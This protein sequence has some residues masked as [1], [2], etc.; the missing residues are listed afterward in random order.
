[1]ISYY[2][3]TRGSNGDSL[4]VTML[5]HI[6]SWGHTYLYIPL[7]GTLLSVVSCSGSSLSVQT[8]IQCW[9][10]S[11]TLFCVLGL[12]FAALLLV[13]E[14]SN[15]VLLFNNNPTSGCITARLSTEIMTLVQL[16]KTLMLM[17]SL[18]VTSYEVKK[19]LIGFLVAV[20]YTFFMYRSMSKM[21]FYSA[22]TNLVTTARACEPGVD[23][24]DLYWGRDV[25]RLG[26]P[27]LRRSPKRPV[28]RCRRTP[29]SRLPSNIPGDPRQSDPSHS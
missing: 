19:W 4:V 15:T 1:M 24:A 11:H 28:L 27:Y 7:M 2:D 23:M 8:D 10:V 29:Q 21:I 25:E 26:V 17:V 5:A 3:T 22:F 14:L 18:Y 6:L 12:V 20:P 13:S 16:D 9:T